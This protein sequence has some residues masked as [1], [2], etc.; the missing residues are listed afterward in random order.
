MRRY[1]DYRRY[2]V[3]RSSPP[4]LMKPWILL[5]LVASRTLV[6][7]DS[8]ADLA[9]NTKVDS[10]KVNAWLALAE[11]LENT[12]PKRALG[13]SMQAAGLSKRVKYEKGLLK[14]YRQ[15]ATNYANQSRYDSMLHYN[16]SAYALAQRQKNQYLMGLTLFDMGEGYKQL[17]RYEESLD[18]TFRAL[19]LLKMYPEVEARVY[20]GLQSTY[21]KLKQYEKSI[22]YGTQGIALA[23]AT[24]NDAVLMV[25]LENTGHCYADMDSFEEAHALY[26]EAIALALKNDIVFTQIIC[27]QGK[28]GLAL[29]QGRIS[30][31]KKYAQRSLDLS[32]E[33]GDFSGICASYHNLAL[34]SFMV[35]DL[36]EAED[37][38]LQALAVAREHQYREF[39]SRI[40]FMLSLIYAA[41]HETLKSMQL[42]QE[43]DALFSEVFSSSVA[44]KE[45]EMRNLYETQLKEEQLL[46]QEGQ[47]RQKS[48]QNTFL[49]CTGLGLTLVGALGYRNYSQRQ[50]LAQAR[51]EDL[52]TEKQLMATEA[53]LKGEEQERSHLAKDLHDGL[54]GM[55]SGIK[56]SLSSMKESMVLRPDHALAFERSLDMLD[57]SIKEMRRV[58]HNMMPELLLKYGLE[59]ALSEFCREISASEMAHVNFHSM[60]VENVNHSTAVSIYRICQ[61][62]VHNSIKHGQAREILVQLHQDA[63]TVAL[64]VEDD[65]KG[66]DPSTLAQSTGMGWKNIQSRVEFLKGKWDLKCS[67]GSSVHIEIPL[68]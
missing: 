26:D 23:R 3:F 59:T 18:H 37:L 39:E 25:L 24:Q 65:G 5:L 19:P 38:E 29:R 48:T 17:G 63:G 46:V 8:L 52:E 28:V 56:Y 36:Q 11:Q 16:Q 60:G 33:V 68:I 66:F 67:K 1:A 15:I 31:I 21:Y 7:Q 54:G 41:Q 34:H 32:R 22:A 30:A 13:Y 51:I 61:E 2:F 53:V 9:R 14:A 35:L 12:A 50:K 6:A 10:L 45:V 27:Y 47:L 40:L 4:I 58:A 64:T 42:S 62:L 57:S 44:E 20:S 43:A 55:L 49:L